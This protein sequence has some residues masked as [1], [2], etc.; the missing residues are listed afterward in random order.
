M[1]YKLKLH[2]DK[3]HTL[4]ELIA[5][6]R[7]LAYHM[8]PLHSEYI[9]DEQLVELRKGEVFAGRL[10]A[11]LAAHYD[12]FRQRKYEIKELPTTE[13]RTA[14]RKHLKSVGK[15]CG[16]FEAELIWRLCATRKTREVRHLLKLLDLHHIPTRRVRPAMSQSDSLD[17]DRETGAVLVRI[18]AYEPL[19]NGA[20]ITCNSE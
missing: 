8:R 12:A 6:A 1:Q 4:A 10:V 5:E 13:E 18:T 17:S 9:I 3:Q 15:P 2:D 7:R 16:V 11:I 19:R 14:M 20:V